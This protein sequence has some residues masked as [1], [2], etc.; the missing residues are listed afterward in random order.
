MQGREKV[1]GY[2]RVSTD[3]EEQATSYSAQVDYYTRYIKRIR[4]GS[5]LEF[6]QMKASRQRI[7][8]IVMASIR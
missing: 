4:N 5:L 8:V 3:T 1:A 6:T 7:P 2:A